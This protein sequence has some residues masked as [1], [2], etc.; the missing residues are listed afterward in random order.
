MELLNNSIGQNL[1]SDLTEKDFSEKDAM[2]HYFFHLSGFKPY[3]HDRETRALDLTASSMSNLLTLNGI[4]KKHDDLVKKMAK[5]LS[6]YRKA[7]KCAKMANGH[8]Y[9]T[10][11]LHQVA[12][13]PFFK[14]RVPKNQV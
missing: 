12:M 14:F 8:T 10:K 5:T 2:R 13:K 1:L 9:A 6:S 4:N 11:F 3:E 7:Q